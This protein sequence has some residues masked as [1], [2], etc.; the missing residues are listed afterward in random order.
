MP[1]A[2]VLDFGPDPFAENIGKFAEGF[3]SSFF[4]NEERKKNEE[5]FDR[6]KKAY[7][8]DANPERMFKDILEAEGL[9]EDYKKDLLK[10]VK[11][12]ATLAGKKSLTPYQ[13]ELL[14]I[15]K[16]DLQ[17]KKDK[18][19]QPDKAIS[20]YQKKLIEQREAT[21]AL[22]RQR[23]EEAAKKA[24]N[25][26]PKLVS[27]YTNSILKDTGETLSS[28]DKAALNSRVQANIKDDGMPIEEAVNEALD[29]IEMKNQIVEGAEIT[30]RPIKWMGLANP[31]PQEVEKVMEQVFPEL[32]QLY[33]VGI[34][35]Q[36]DLRSIAKRAGWLPAEITKM[37]QV[38]YQR[39]GKKFRTKAPDSKKEAAQQTAG[40]D[41]ILFGE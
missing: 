32:E 9:D 25:S 22:Q 23:I 7:G 4:K 39:K 21:L 5:V 31:S 27:D 8:K 2:Q 3:S 29:Y 11:E 38:L 15:R 35:S 12:Y 14:E 19:A 17:L 26:F 28:G 36:K 20:P 10:E 37:L 33:D 41:D 40:L 1:S 24:D 30:P 16:E 13:A 34:E 6:I 18:A